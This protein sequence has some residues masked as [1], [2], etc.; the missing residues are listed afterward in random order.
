MV[1]R[2]RFAAKQMHAIGPQRRRAVQRNIVAHTVAHREVGD[3]ESQFFGELSGQRGALGF[4]G[5]D[6]TAG[7][8]PT[9]RQLRWPNALRHQ[10]RATA[11][12]G[13]GNHDLIQHDL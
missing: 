3:L 2:T 7:K 6:L 9:T 13:S 12:D 10:D 11:D 5:G 1:T 4:A 8:F